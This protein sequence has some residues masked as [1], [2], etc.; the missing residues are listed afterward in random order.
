MLAKC[1][2]G[3][4][5]KNKQAI[6]ITEHNNYEIYYLKEWGEDGLKFVKYDGYLFPVGFNIE[7]AQ[8]TL[9]NI[10]DFKQALIGQFEYTIRQC[11]NISM[12]LAQYLNRVDEAVKAKEEQEKI[13]QEQKE[14]ELRQQRIKEAEEEI[15]KQA[16]EKF[17]NGELIDA[18]LFVKLCDKYNI[19]LPLKTR[20]W[21][22]KTLVYIS[23]DNYK[24]KKGGN[25]STVI[26]NYVDKLMEVLTS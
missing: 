18:E 20:G 8:K 12:G 22:L 3:S 23:K 21:C 13:R 24:Y 10:P 9:D 16:K 2:L 7:H 14:E 11:K 6:K 15:L 17:K 5:I 26:Y 19:K 25:T 4:G 1:V